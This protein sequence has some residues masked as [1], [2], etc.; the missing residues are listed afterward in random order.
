MTGTIPRDPRVRWRDAESGRRYR[1]ERWRSARRR[2]RDPLLVRRVLATRLSGSGLVLDAPCGTGRLRDAIEAHGRWVALD[3]SP[4]MLA[5]T[6]SARAR[7]RGDVERLPFRD[8]AFEAVVCC[9]LLHH[10]RGQA[11]L[12]RTV[13]ELVRVSA[14]WIVASF[15]D[16]ASLP[17][18]KRR[19]LAP[20]RRGSRV[21]RS[22]RDVAAAFHAA[23]AAIVGW[24]HSL[25][26]LSQQTFVVARKSGRPEG[27]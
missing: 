1:T 21:A 12:E 14:E 7:L 8:G 25:R 10:L 24:E 11:R 2:E 22:K 5:A 26:F 27:G 18:W 17:A 23:G 13:H 15:W 6:E 9:R 4:Q 16:A 20:A 19:L 3:L